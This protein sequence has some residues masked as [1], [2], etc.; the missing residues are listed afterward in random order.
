MLKK[1]L[2]I[3]ALL[4]FILA[5]L[6]SCVRYPIPVTSVTETPAAGVS[7]TPVASMS[8]TPSASV[9]ETPATGEDVLTGFFNTFLPMVKRSVFVSPTPEIPPLP[10]PG[11][12]DWTTVAANPQRTSWSAE[13]IRGNNL[14]VAWYR[15]IEAYISQNVQLIASNGLIYVAT[16]RGLY[17]LQAETGQEVW[18]F[19][20]ELP[21]GNSPTVVGDV[22]YVGGL[23]HK[24]YALDALNGHLLWSFNGAAAGYST[25]PLVVE[26][27]VLL[28]NRDGYFYAIG[29]NGTTRQGQQLWKYKTEGSIELTAAYSDGVVYFASNDNHAYALRS[30]NGSLVWK[31]ELLPGD[32]YG[33]YW[34]VIYGDYVV[35]SA[36]SGYRTGLN[37]GTAS[38]K[39]ARGNDYAKIFDMDKDGVFRN[40]GDGA[41]IGPEVSNQTWA[42]GKKVLNG[43]SIVNYLEEGSHPERRTLIVLKRSNGVEFTFDSDHDGK[44]EYAPV[45]MVGTQSGNAYPPV[46]GSDGVLYFSTILQK[47]NIPQSRVMGWLMGTPYLSQAGGQ[48]AID[49][50]QALSGGGNTFY[51]NLCCDRVGDWFGLD[52]PQS[53]QMW[54]YDSPLS[55]QIPGY[56]QMWYGTVDGDSV[57]LEGNF[58]T[59]N[60]IYNAH[61]DQNPIIPYQGRLYVHRSNA[62]IAYG[63]ERTSGAQPLL[64]I[65]YFQNDIVSKPT[66]EIQVMLTNEVQKM[67][68]AGHLRP[69][70]YNAGQFSNYSQL[71]NYFE[72]PGETL[73]ALS[74]A[75]PYLS[76][77]VKPAAKQYLQEEFNLYFNPTMVTKTGWKDGAPREWM[78]IPDDIEDE[79][80]SIGPVVGSDPRFSWP[81]PPLNFYALW[82]YALVVPEDVQIAYSQAKSKLVVPV[83][84]NATN[85][86]LYQRP[87][88]HNAYIAGYYGFLQLQTLAGKAS[89]DASLRTSVTNELN[90]LYNLRVQNFNKDTIWVNGQGSYHLR[91]LNIS[92]NFIYLVP[93]LA[94]YLQQNIYAKI[95]GALKE[96]ND[97]A[98]YWFVSRFN[99]VVNEGVRQ[100][101]YDYGALFQAYAYAQ[102]SNSQNLQKYLDVPAFAVG[103]LFYINNLIAVIEAAN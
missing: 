20:T 96:Y 37:P 38:L 40:L 79:L 7:E 83:P 101:L 80:N 8:E 86:Y 36:A 16:A 76:S 51:R 56:D 18:R 90:R 44:A 102:N 47:L 92:R 10:P 34:P 66:S 33:S 17:A 63:S 28:G 74:R 1:T 9:T 81:Y 43:S 46:V 94:D 82:Q 69:G 98:P 103:D 100:N 48:H 55:V 2:I 49:E 19:N 97:D 31:S 23:D 22:L 21:L 64:R 85:D 53:Y 68:N 70:Y 75:F 27:Q 65:Q 61:G 60:G 84:A 45:V 4:I 30:N 62:I 54:R 14:K 35:F 25:N 13:D 99:G 88:E 5:S 32:G 73:Y 12:G 52:S 11:N 6:A 67:I 3:A 91:T 15:P 87:Y 57:R 29:A 41:F 50:P 59:K 89:T 77:S 26:N 93:E 95:E 42:N 39:D 24:L 58:G 72:N 78:P 71:A